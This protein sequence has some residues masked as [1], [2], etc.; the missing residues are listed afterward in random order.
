M[1]ASS[2]KH[3]I[4]D[5]LEF[6]CDPIVSTSQT[7]NVSTS[8]TLEYYKK[9]EEL[10]NILNTDKDKT[11]TV[12]FSKTRDANISDA[13]LSSIYYKK[14]SKPWLTN[15]YI[16]L[17]EILNYFPKILNT[18]ENDNSITGGKNENIEIINI[19]NEQSQVNIKTVSNKITNNETVSYNVNSKLNDKLSSAE[20]NT[21][22]DT[23]VHFDNASF[24]GTWIKSLESFCNVR[25]IKR[26]WIASSFILLGSQML[27]DKYNLYKNNKDKWLMEKD[28]DGNVSDLE[29]IEKIKDK[30]ENKVNL[31]TSD[32]GIDIGTNYNLQEDLNLEPQIGQLLCGLL[33]L[34]ENGTFIVKHYTFFRPL[35]I[36]VVYLVTLCFEE[37]Y[38]CKPCTSRADNSESYLV[39]FKFKQNKS[40]YSI[41]ELKQIISDYKTHY[42][43]PKDWNTR[44]SAQKIRSLNGLDEINKIKE[45]KEKEKEEITINSGEPIG[46]EDKD[47][48][49]ITISSQ[50]EPVSDSKS[51]FLNLPISY[52]DCMYKISKKLQERQSYVLN[53]ISCPMAKGT[54]TNKEKYVYKVKEQ[55]K[56]W[57]NKH[58][59]EL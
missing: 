52:L 15:G 6:I 57:I 10:E 38:I 42:S 59:K 41:D 11:E 24:P 32:L 43:N 34:K 3:E 7:L 54:F 22:K 5:N 53:N 48:E 29:Y 2:G 16:K 49:D 45:E 25:N 26:D 23:L 58:S 17:T 27:D 31:Y 50:N 9:L 21:K 13:I 39:G 20:E 47:K 19:L 30:I 51:K 4:F 14:K 44:P 55:A 36:Y 37:C 33:S 56:E 8:Q 1:N 40:A 46:K 12:D 18:E 35:T 28:G